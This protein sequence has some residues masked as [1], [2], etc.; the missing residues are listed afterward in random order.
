M[1][2][3]TNRYKDYDPA[4]GTAVRITYGRPRFRTPYTLYQARLITPGSWFLKG[5]DAWFTRKYLDMLTEAGTDAVRAELEAIGE[6]SGSDKLVL[7]CFD[8]VGKGLCHRSLFAS[9][10]EQRTGE[11]VEELQKRRKESRGYAD[12]MLL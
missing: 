7:L 12:V 3:Y 6:Q 4:Q 1:K 11:K 2:I 10:W 9:W 8:D 5:S